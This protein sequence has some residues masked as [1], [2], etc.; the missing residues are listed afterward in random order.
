MQIKQIGRMNFE[1]I[2]IPFWQEYEVGNLNIENGILKDLDACITSID[3]LEE[4]I[5]SDPV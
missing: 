1:N 2:K 5:K 4:N 3:D